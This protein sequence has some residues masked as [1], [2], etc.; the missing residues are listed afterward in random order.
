ME[1]RTPENLFE[2]RWA[3]ALLEQAMAKL[4]AEFGASG[5]QGRF[6]K[7]ST[8]LN[9]DPE[10]ASYEN[11]AAELGGSPG[12]LRVTVHRLRRRFRELLRAVI[13][14]TVAKP[15]EIDEEIRF[16]MATLSKTS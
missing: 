3:L 1:Q 12:A 16:L 9:G 14:E 2:R 6:E 13:A 15:E 5:R 7:L 11:L 10:G 4:R 8:F